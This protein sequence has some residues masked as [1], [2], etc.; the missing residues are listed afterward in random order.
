MTTH[1][2]SAS[3][4][5]T[6]DSIVRSCGG[7]RTASFLGS[8]VRHKSLLPQVCSPKGSEWRAMFRQ[9]SLRN[10]RLE[11]RPKSDDRTSVSPEHRMRC[12]LHRSDT[13]EARERGR[14]VKYCYMDSERIYQNPTVTT[15]MTKHPATTSHALRPPSGKYSSSSILGAGITCTTISSLLPSPLDFSSAVDITGEKR[16]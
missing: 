14:L 12:G 7:K 1:Y 2:R 16:G 6:T 9:G 10:S 11:K 15:V 5:V 3:F 8:Q 13:H 4:P